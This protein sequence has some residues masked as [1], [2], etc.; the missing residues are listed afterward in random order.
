MPASCSGGPA[1]SLAIHGGNCYEEYTGLIGPCQDSGTEV[2][3]KACLR[4][5]KI[6]TPSLFDLCWT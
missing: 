4:K 3:L 2:Y 5:I 6:L 1:A